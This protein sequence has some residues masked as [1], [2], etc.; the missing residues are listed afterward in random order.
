MPTTT[1]PSKAI[2][3]TL[4][5]LL[6]HL[7]RMPTLS[8]DHAT[9]RAALDWIEEQ[10]R[11][12]PL[13]IKRFE[14]HG[15]PS[16]VATTQNTKNPHL[17]LAAHLDVVPGPPK[18]FD[19]HIQNGRLY[20]RG[21][22]DMKA[23][24]AV[25]IALLQQMG[26]ALTT[27]DLGLMIT[28]DEEVG[29]MNGVGHLVNKGYR[30]GAAYLP[31]SGASWTLEMGAKGVIWLEVTASGKAAHASRPWEGTSAID[32]ITNFMTLLRTNF[33]I[34]PCGDTDHRHATLNLGT[35]A[36][37]TVANQVADSAT[38][39]IDIRV[40][41]ETGLA[42]ARNWIEDAA[43]RTPG[44]EVKFLFAEAP[45]AVT[46]QRPIQ[47]ISRIVKDVTGQ[48]PAASIAHG[49]SDARFFAAHNIPTINLSPLGSGFHLPEE[50]V[51]IDSL[52][53]FYEVTRQFVT[54]W[55]TPI[56]RQVPSEA[57]SASP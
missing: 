57:Q 36:G 18:S 51:D 37:G 1:E 14:S 35:I 6:S 44:I 28:T 38:A 21:V 40:P 43:A 48:A 9:N 5:D 49:S 15:H 55:C 41:A 54:E 34:E 10:L 56:T 2:T 42:T 17:W 16:L 19:P 46:H 24:I 26:T 27:T 30:G 11:S 39:R 7:V 12:L 50:W 8:A 47:L 31:D 25:F 13:Y 4:T 45:Y 33:K 23:A 22:H 52:N 53:D 29:G 3:E 20:G 32:Q